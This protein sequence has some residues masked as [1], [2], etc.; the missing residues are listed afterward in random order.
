MATYSSNPKT[1]ALMAETIR[2]ILQDDT[3]L[4]SLMEEI[5]SQPDGQKRL[6]PYWNSLSKKDGITAIVVAQM[7]KAMGGDTSAFTALAKYGFGEKVQLETSAFDAING[8]QIE[9]INPEAIPEGEPAKDDVP[10]IEPGEV[11]A[12]A[13]NSIRTFVGQEEPIEKESEIMDEEE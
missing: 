11:V 9:V 13:S 2:T 4:E 1:T 8:F 6:P 3:L 12:E 10:E 7:L 5:A